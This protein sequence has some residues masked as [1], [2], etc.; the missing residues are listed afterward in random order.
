MCSDS[1]QINKNGSYKDEFDSLLSQIY[2]NSPE[3]VNIKPFFNII[4]IIILN[5]KYFK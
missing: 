3:K 5:Y 1:I 4:I 2:I